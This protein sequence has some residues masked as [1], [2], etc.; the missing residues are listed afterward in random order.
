MV[1]DISQRINSART[2][3]RAIVVEKAIPQ[4]FR[5]VR[6]GGERLKETCFVLEEA[7]PERIGKIFWRTIVDTRRN[8]AINGTD[9]N[10]IAVAPGVLPPG[11]QS[12]QSSLLGSMDEWSQRR[13]HLI[14]PLKLSSKAGHCSLPNTRS[15]NLV[16]TYDVSE[17]TNV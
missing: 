10:A 8:V 13:A 11:R 14:V 2:A 5:A 15:R 9:E 16:V 1:L 3:A 17:G 6:R 4:I 7:S 12:P